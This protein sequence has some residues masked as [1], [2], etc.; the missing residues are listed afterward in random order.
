MDELTIPEN[1]LA[2]KDEAC[3]IAEKAAREQNTDILGEY[4]RRLIEIRE[5]IASSEKG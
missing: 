5:S 4:E 1:V 3:G 2:L